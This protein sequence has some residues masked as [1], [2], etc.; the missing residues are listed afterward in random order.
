MSKDVKIRTA[1]IVVILVLSFIVVISQRRPMNSESFDAQAK[2]GV[3]KVIAQDSSIVSDQFDRGALIVKVSEGD[4]NSAYQLALHYDK[5]GVPEAA[6]YWFGVA[7]KLGRKGLTQ[8]HLD[9]YEG[10]IMDE[11]LPPKEGGGPGAPGGS[12]K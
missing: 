9:Y 6:F 11:F 4:A 7:M 3:D 10:Q 2:H 5:H 1:L 12:P 8:E